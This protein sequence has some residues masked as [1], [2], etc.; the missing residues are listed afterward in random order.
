MLPLFILSKNSTLFWSVPS[1]WAIPINLNWVLKS[2]QAIKEIHFV[3]VQL[4]KLPLQDIFTHKNKLWTYHYISLQLKKPKKKN[5]KKNHSLPSLAIK[6]TTLTWNIVFKQDFFRLSFH[7]KMLYAG[8]TT[9]GQAT[10]HLDWIISRDQHTGSSLL[11][12]DSW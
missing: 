4:I 7:V 8:F 9:K 11:S 6:L 5:Q 10:E 1:K 2:M 3:A 12:K